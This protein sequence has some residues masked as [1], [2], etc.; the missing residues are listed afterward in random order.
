MSPSEY[1]QL[2]EFLGQQFTAIDQRFVAIDRASW[3]WIGDWRRSKPPRCHSAR[4]FLVISTSSTGASTG[5]TRNILID[6]RVQLGT[7]RF[8]EAAMLLPVQRQGIE[9]ERVGLKI[10]QLDVVQLD[11]R[12]DRARPV[13]LPGLRSG[14]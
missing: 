8:E 5:S 11:G 1:Q 12:L 13:V 2:V 7:P 10:E 3:P 4:K 9:L 6:E 14:G